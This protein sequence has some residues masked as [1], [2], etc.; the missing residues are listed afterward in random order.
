MKSWSASPVLKGFYFGPRRNFC[1]GFSVLPH[2]GNQ[3]PFWGGTVKV[4]P[5]WDTER[6]AEQMHRT[7]C[8]SLPMGSVNDK[9]S[10]Y[11]CSKCTLWQGFQLGFFV[12][13]CFCFWRWSYPGGR[14]REITKGSRWIW[15]MLT[16][17]GLSPYYLPMAGGKHSSHMVSAG[18]QCYSRV[19]GAGSAGCSPSC[20]ARWAGAALLGSSVCLGKH[21]VRRSSPVPLGL[22]ANVNQSS[23]WLPLN[24]GKWLLFSIF[25][26][27]YFI[28]VAQNDAAIR[29]Q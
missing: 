19:P 28:I 2:C 8:S 27:L 24:I 10:Q 3:R 5:L 22:L 13:F 25:Y 9:S 21:D 7:C 20:A 29:K 4:P 17:N 12:L 16:S 23:L 6:W 14:G 15:T 18:L 26:P 1:V 11:I